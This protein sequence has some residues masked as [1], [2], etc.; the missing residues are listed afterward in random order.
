ME[1]NRFHEARRPQSEKLKK[2]INCF[3]LDQCWFCTRDWSAT[4]KMDPVYDKWVCHS[5]LLGQACNYTETIDFKVV[6]AARTKPTRSIR[7]RWMVFSA[8]RVFFPRSL[9]SGFLQNWPL[10]PPG[11]VS[12]PHLAHFST[13]IWIN[14]S[15]NYAGE[16]TWSRTNKRN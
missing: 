7:Q 1:I 4:Q 6:P 14:W 3:Q 2:Q 10:S 9:P 16:L 8:P 13:L 11:F 15:G 5:P 12:L